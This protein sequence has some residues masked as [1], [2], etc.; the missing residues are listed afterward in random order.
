MVSSICY[1]FAPQIG[2]HRTDDGLQKPR[3]R[4]PTHQRVRGVSGPSS[5]AMTTN[6]EQTPRGKITRQKPVL[7]LKFSTYFVSHVSFWKSACEQNPSMNPPK[8]GQAA[9]FLPN[10]Q[11]ILVRS[12]GA[13]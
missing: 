9:I 4:P 5:L 3:T 6:P 1:L 2:Q 8:C 7:S 12:L 11:G 13:V 10:Y